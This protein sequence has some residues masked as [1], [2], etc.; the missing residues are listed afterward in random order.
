MLQAEWNYAVG[1]QEM[2]AIVMSCCQWHR[3]LESARDLVEFLTDHH[4][5]QRFMTTKSL[6]CW[7]ACLWEMLLGYNLNRV[8]KAGKKNPANAPSWQPDYVRVPEGRCATT[9]LTVHCSV[10]FCLRQLY[11]AAVQEDQIF[12]AV[13]HDTLCNF[14]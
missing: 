2:L 8:Y 14:I 9:I 6:M 13:P 11:A 3:Y 5:L 4:N 7:Q 12:E 1:N 10:T